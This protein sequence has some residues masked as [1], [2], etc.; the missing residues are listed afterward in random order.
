MRDEQLAYLMRIAEVAEEEA[1]LCEARESFAAFCNYVMMDD[2][3]QRWDFAD[4]Q[5]EWSALM[6]DPNIPLLEIVAP[7]NSAKSTTVQGRILWELGR[8]PNLCIKYVCGNDPRA[9]DRLHLLRV[10]ILS[11]QR[12]RKV[13][14]HVEQVEESEQTKHKLTIERSAAVGQQDASIEC[15][16]VRA[17]GTGTRCHLLILDDVID[18]TDALSRPGTIA[19]IK[20]FVE[21]DW[22]ST[23][24]PGGRAWLIGTF[25][26]F[27]PPDLYVE[28]SA[29]HSPWETWCR[30]A[31]EMDA[32]GNL[33][34][35]V[36]W[37]NKWPLSAL[38][39]RRK[40]VGEEAFQQQYLLRGAVQR[41]HYFADEHIAACKNAS[42]S[43]GESPLD[44]VKVGIGFDPATA[45]TKKWGSYACIFVVAVGRCGRKVPLAIVREKA[46][47][48]LLTEVL[49]HQYIHW[50]D[51][52]GV[53]IRIIV[54]NNGTQ[55]AFE[56]LI[57]L[58][59][60]K[61][62]LTD[63]PISGQFTGW[64]K[65]SP[66]TGLPFLSAE[67]AQQKW[68][69]PVGGNHGGPENPFHEC[70]LC[71]WLDEMK[72]WGKLRD[73]KGRKP[74]ID[75]IMA[76]WLASTAA[77]DAANIGDIPVAVSVERRPVSYGF[78]R[79]I[80]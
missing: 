1:L 50:R 25:W 15:A 34:E 76:C 42:V 59:G 40:Q 39:L 22:M 66:E 21:Q 72:F 20:Q 26:S 79:Q 12:Y 54:E 32:A 2:V 3:G 30:P 41:S 62:G 46:D 53:P 45:L 36:L 70:H 52:L 13:F 60:E 6:D 44:V 28:Y 71:T 33:T 37:P 55:K 17:G 14:P 18:S 8:N 75:T 64:N 65:W 29:E 11:N 10:N 35:P 43:L 48:E 61:R 56:T 49:I 7:R 38:D 67:F 58:I 69:I 23:L 77:S 31:C 27:D 68:I 63:L 16:S 73:D 80:A 47:P 74:T 4:H 5:Y 78:T 51:A 24:H 57:R 19:E 9:I